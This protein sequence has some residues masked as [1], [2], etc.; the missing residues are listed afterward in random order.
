MHILR[1]ARENFLDI[2]NASIKGDATRYDSFEN[3]YVELQTDTF[4]Y[5]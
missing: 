3:K 2:K 1:Y 5:V 4:K